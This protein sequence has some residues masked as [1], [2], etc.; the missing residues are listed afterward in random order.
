MLVWRKL[1]SAKWEDVW[2]ERLRFLDPMRIAIFFG[3]GTKT[4]RIE[5]YDVT[6][7]EAAA[8]IE[9]F[10]G[11]VR[12]V[13]KNGRDFIAANS[14]PRPPLRIRGKLAIVRTEAEREALSFRPALVIPAAMAFGTGDHATTA[15]CLRLLADVSETLPRGGWEMLDLG[16]GS[17]ILALAARA[18]GASRADAWDF[19]PACIRA[20]RENLALNRIKNVRLAR[21]DVLKWSPERTW[22]IVTANLYSGIL[23]AA[24][25][26][27]A[28]AVA[29]GG[30]LIFSGILREQE[31]ACVRAFAAENL[32]IARIVRRGKWVAALA[33]K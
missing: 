1:S 22:H 33:Q 5:A 10:G 11:A 23:T 8:L 9:H 4:I 3:P 17:G 29:P 12:E 15:A 14:A 7:K 21:R 19:D 30:A 18:L 27:I 20:A 2:F 6:E 24:A 26:Q 28:R 25:P 31:T 16:A 32:R 13:K